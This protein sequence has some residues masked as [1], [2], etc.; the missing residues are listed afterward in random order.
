MFFW[1]NFLLKC[2]LSTRTLCRNL[3]ILNPRPHLFSTCANQQN[4]ARKI[5][6]QMGQFIFGGGVQM[7][8]TVC[9]G[10]KNWGQ[11]GGGGGY[12]FSICWSHKSGKCWKTCI[13]YCNTFSNFFKWKICKIAKRYI[14]QKICFLSCLHAVIV[15]D[16]GIHSFRPIH[17]SSPLLY[18]LP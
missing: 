6:K 14:P 9:R 10:E 7:E 11:F 12:Y 13:L 18:K 15:V 17:H 3:D 8:R 5:N 4:F 16:C 1:I 2:R